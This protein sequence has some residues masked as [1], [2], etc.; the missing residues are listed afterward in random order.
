MSSVK[1]VD[2]L[3]KLR[4]YLNDNNV[5][6]AAYRYKNKRFSRFIK[7]KIPLDDTQ[8][9]QR[10]LTE[11]AIHQ[12]AEMTRGNQAKLETL[13]HGVQLMSGIG[14]ANLMLNAVNL[15]ATCVGFAIVYKEM[16]QMGAE[17]NRQLMQLD[18]T[19]RKSFD[20]E[21]KFRFNEVLSIIMKCLTA[22]SDRSLIPKKKCED[23]SI[24]ST[25]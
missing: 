11:K 13:A 3:E 14:Y 4:K 9:Q 12:I 5:L 2:S 6:E 16:K 19:V 18:E 23:L 1:Y 8:N 24:A 21:H 22:L 15:C 25:A 20:I 10:E 7:I 17:I